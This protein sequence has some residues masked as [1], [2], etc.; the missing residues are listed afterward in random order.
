MT[1]PLLVIGIY[2]DANYKLSKGSKEEIS[3]RFSKK[4]S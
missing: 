2:L 3:R 4:F 1:T